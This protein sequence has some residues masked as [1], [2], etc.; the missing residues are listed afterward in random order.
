M[1]HCRF[2]LSAIFFSVA[3][4]SVSL[5]DGYDSLQWGKRLVGKLLTT[6]A[7]ASPLDCAEECLVRPGC[8]SFN[9]KRAAIFCELNYENDTRSNTRLKDGDGWIYGQ[10]EHWPI[11]ITEECKNIKCALNQKC[12]RNSYLSTR[13]EL[14]HCNTGWIC[15]D[16]GNCYR[17]ISTPLMTQEA[18]M[19]SC[20]ICDSY[21][22]EINDTEESDWLTENVL[23]NVSCVNMYECTTWTGGNDKEREGSYIWEYSRSPIKNLKWS[24]GNPDAVYPDKDC[25]D[26]FYFGEFNDR[27]C[28]HKNGFMCERD[29]N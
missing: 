4:T 17:R 18:A 10:K 26:M 29:G 9:Y 2:F 5:K 24:R 8:L 3:F 16:K 19:K 27:P 15:K 22:V 25:V 6:I 23:K 7:Q 11:E 21:L 1:I 14:A 20:R 12:I 28:N 13:C